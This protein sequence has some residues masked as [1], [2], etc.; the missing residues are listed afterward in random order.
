MAILLQD[1]V[2]IP[3]DKIVFYGIQ[4]AQGV[5]VLGMIL[6][7]FLKLVPTWERIK[8]R[9]FDLRDKEVTVRD[10]EAQALKLMS[11]NLFA[12]AVEQRRASDATKVLQHANS[13]DIDNY[14]EQLDV[15]EER[16]G[17]VEKK[18]AAAA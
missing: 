6:F 10:A 8:G 1:A 18:V 4:G 11:E 7:V 2:S 12:V 15:F 3:W 13:R 16:L 17:E 9:E 14:V 5:L